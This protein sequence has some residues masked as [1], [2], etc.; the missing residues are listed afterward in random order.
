MDTK[1]KIRQFFGNTLENENIGDDD[2][3]LL[4]GIIDSLKMMD[5]IE[6]LEKEFSLKVD[7]DELMPDNFDSINAIASFLEGKQT[8][9]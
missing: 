1:N 8:A 4:A 5:L 2:S 9:A 7:E 6:Y 3:L